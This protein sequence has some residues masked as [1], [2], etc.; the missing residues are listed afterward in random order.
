MKA[1]NKISKNATAEIWS[2]DTRSN[3]AQVKLEI[4]GLS[5]E[6][7]AKLVAFLKENCI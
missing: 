1:S 7:T 2:V 4:N 3:T 5:L 6:T